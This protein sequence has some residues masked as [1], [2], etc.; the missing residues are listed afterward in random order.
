MIRVN[1]DPLDW[2]E[3]LTVQGILEARNYR[4]PLVIVTVNGQIVAK[5]D[6]FVRDLVRIDLPIAAPSPWAAA[7]QAGPS[8]SAARRRRLQRV[9]TMHSGCPPRRRPS[10]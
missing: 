7:I 10:P 3:G 8:A 5:P 4:F 9:Q 2:R 6:V 1:G